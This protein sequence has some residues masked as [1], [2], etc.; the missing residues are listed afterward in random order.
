MYREDG[1]IVEFKDYTSGL[2]LFDVS[3]QGKNNTSSDMFSTES[4][5]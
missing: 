3:E 4:I 2:Y 5:P 1:L